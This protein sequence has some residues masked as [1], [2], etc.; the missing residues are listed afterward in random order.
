MVGPFLQLN[1]DFKKNN[2]KSEP[3]CP[4]NA[5]AGKLSFRLERQI[6]IIELIGVHRIASCDINLFF[7]HMHIN[8][9][10]RHCRIRQDSIV[11]CYH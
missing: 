9:R 5:K 7:N 4:D 6:G 3:H 8:K 10:V 2:S 1:N 11:F